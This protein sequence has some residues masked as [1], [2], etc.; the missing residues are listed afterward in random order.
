MSPPSSIEAL[1]NNKIDLWFIDPNKLDLKAMSTIK[2][3]LSMT[4]SENIHQ[5]KN[6]IAQHTAIVTRSICRLVLAQY[7]SLPPSEIHFIR[8]QHGKPE[9]ESNPLK[10]RF[11][12]SH[13]N[14]LII[15]AVCVKDDIGCDIENPLRKVSIEPITRRYFSKQEHNKLCQLSGLKQQ[16]RFFEYWTLKEAFVKAT[17]IGISLGLDSFYFS[18]NDQQNENT[19]DN[20][21]PSI[22]CDNVS[23]F[24]NDNYPLN[25]NTQWQL[26]QRHL[27]DQI[28][29]VCRASNAKQNI[30]LLDASTLIV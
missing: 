21:Q 15:M 19:N 24:F 22:T 4:E 13:N 18:F 28:V 8:N 14:Q 23:L 16:Q 30:T 6:K 9:L 25:K 27:N 5:F 11:N 20:I 7:V 17:G 26:H 3:T 2:S 1:K 12:L 10:I 29:A